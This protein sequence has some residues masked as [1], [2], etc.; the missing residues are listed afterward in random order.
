MKNSLAFREKLIF[1]FG[2]TLLNII[3]KTFIRRTNFDKLFDGH[4]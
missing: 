1:E 3:G 2:N 4:E